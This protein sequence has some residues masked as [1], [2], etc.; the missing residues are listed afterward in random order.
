MDGIQ[1]SNTKKNYKHIFYAHDGIP[2]DR[3]DK[4]NVQCD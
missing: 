1:I 2:L 4:L 3:H